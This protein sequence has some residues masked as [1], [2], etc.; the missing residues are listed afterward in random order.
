M[1]VPRTCGSRISEV[2]TDR[3]PNGMQA[4]PTKFHSEI[5]N[6]MTTALNMHLA[7]I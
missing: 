4:L 2:D 3:S 6:K 7:S 5:Q 1:A